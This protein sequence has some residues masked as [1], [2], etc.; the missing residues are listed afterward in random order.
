MAINL[1]DLAYKLTPEDY[2]KIILSAGDYFPGFYRF[3]MGSRTN[4]PGQMS[5]SGLLKL[6]FSQQTTGKIRTRQE[7]FKK[8]LERLDS[9]DLRLQSRS[10]YAV[11]KLL[12]K[13][14]RNW[15]MESNQYE[16]AVIEINNKKKF[17]KDETYFFMGCLIR[18]CDD[19][20]CIGYNDYDKIS[21]ETIFVE[22]DKISK[23][24]NEMYQENFSD[25]FIP[26]KIVGKITFDSNN[27]GLL[28]I[29]EDLLNHLFTTDTNS[30]VIASN[31]TKSS[32]LSMRW[33][34]DISLTEY[35]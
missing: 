15:V 7:W 8:S 2:I 13:K 17:L 14:Y 18:F 22:F 1:F 24:I 5:I 20:V 34:K 3:T 31:S 21:V 32:K 11:Y 27:D 12:D 29:K 28:E 26:A 35:E 23:I 9:L 4:E 30:V 25:L 6:Y 33:A 10:D 16:I 19:Y